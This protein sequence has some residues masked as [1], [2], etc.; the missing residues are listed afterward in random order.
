MR[1]IEIDLA[2]LMNIVNYGDVFGPRAIIEDLVEILEKD[3]Y[4]TKE[5]VENFIKEVLPA[6][7]GYGDG[8]FDNCRETFKDI[9]KEKECS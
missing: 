3:V 1:K 5:D 7:K 2:D 9:I 8:D 4:L 6:T